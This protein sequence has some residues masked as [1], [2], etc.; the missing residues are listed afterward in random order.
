[1]E[2]LVI[3]LV[4]LRF[5]IGLLDWEKYKLFHLLKASRCSLEQQQYSR[6]P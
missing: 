3:H 5:T 2:Q 1:M 4:N 6:E